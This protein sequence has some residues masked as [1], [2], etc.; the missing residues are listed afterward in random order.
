ME[1]GRTEGLPAHRGLDQFHRG[2]G[3]SRPKGRR[4]SAM[5][6]LRHQDPLYGQPEKPP[7]GHPAGTPETVDV[8][9]QENCSEQMYRPLGDRLGPA[10]PA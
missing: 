9:S 4:T 2:P 5:R 10:E 8:K 1:S 7:T 3:G 6:R